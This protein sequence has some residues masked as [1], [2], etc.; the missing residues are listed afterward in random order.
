[1]INEVGFTQKGFEEFLYW[2]EHDQRTFKKINKLL[3]D[4]A[5]NGNTGIGHPEPLKGNYSGYWSRVIDEKNRLVYKIRDDG[6]ILVHQ[7]KGHYEDK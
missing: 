5:R 3:F 1:M 4:I 6:T 2:G 7:C